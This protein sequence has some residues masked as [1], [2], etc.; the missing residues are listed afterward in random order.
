MGRIE[1]G[2]V[3][4]LKSVKAGNT[5][6]VVKGLSL[7]NTKTVNVEQETRKGVDCQVKLA[8]DCVA[9]ILRKVLSSRSFRM[10]LSLFINAVFQAYS[11]MLLILFRISV[12][13]RVLESLFFIWTICSFF[14]MRAITPF[15]GIIR[16]MTPTP[17]NMLGPT[18]W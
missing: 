15:S 12:I 1:R 13:S 18:S 5:I 7:V 14:I 11:L 6:S 3:S 8:I 9:P 2:N 16:I 10:W 4:K 17:A